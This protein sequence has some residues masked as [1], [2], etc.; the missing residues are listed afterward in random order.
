MWYDGSIGCQTQPLPFSITTKWLNI[1]LEA[2]LFVQLF[3]NVG[4]MSSDEQVSNTV[5]ISQIFYASLMLI[6]SPLN[7]CVPRKLRRLLG[8][9]FVL[10]K[11]VWFFVILFLLLRSVW[12]KGYDLEFMTPVYKFMY[13]VASCSYI[14]IQA[15][16]V[17]EALFK[18]NKLWTEKDDYS[19]N[20]TQL[21]SFSSLFII[22]SFVISTVQMMLYTGTSRVPHGIS[23]INL[24]SAL[25]YIALSIYEDHGSLF[26]SSGVMLYSSVLCYS[27]VISYYGHLVKDIGNV[28]SM[29]LMAQWIDFGLHYCVTG[30]FSV[31]FL[32]YC[33]VGDTQIERFISMVSGEKE[34]VELSSSSYT[35]FHGVMMLA[36]GF[37]Y[38]IKYGISSQLFYVQVG[39][40]TLVVALYTWSLL[41]PSLLQ[42]R[43]F[44]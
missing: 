26:T 29:S 28:G 22:L 7:L 40:A 1:S 44:S 4:F 11:V 33:L 21:I 9:D 2:Y 13:Y 35:L 38:T 20:A 34:V 43:D 3:F 16:F 19:W 31:L 17:L 42:D 8:A 32:S 25:V 37:C 27:G 14:L 36:T 23:G 18:W 5:P 12:W 39:A 24:L 6:S 15:S 10:L 30:L 41:A